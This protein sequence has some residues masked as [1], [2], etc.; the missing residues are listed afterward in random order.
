MASLPHPRERKEG[1]V[2]KHE[3]NSRGLGVVFTL[4]MK[5]FPATRGLMMTELTDPSSVPPWFGV[6]TPA[7]V[8]TVKVTYPIL[9]P[10]FLSVA[11]ER[12]LSGFSETYLY[13]YTSRD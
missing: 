10:I 4:L 1:N 8:L 5:T 7:V 13:T 12:P 11:R 3:Q 2:H 9:A 6:Q